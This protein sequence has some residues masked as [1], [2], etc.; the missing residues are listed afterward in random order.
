MAAHDAPAVSQV[1]FPYAFPRRGSYRIWVQVKLDDTVMTG[2]FDARATAADPE[3]DVTPWLRQL[4]VRAE[5]ARRI[6]ASC[7]A[8]PPETSLAGRV[9]FAVRQLAPPHRHVAATRATAA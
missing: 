9:R 7:E 2:V 4:G 8:L 3:K 5:Q 1:A 6:A